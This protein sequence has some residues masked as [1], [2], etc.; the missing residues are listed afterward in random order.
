MTLLSLY[1]FFF[2]DTATT[3][4]YTLSLHDAL[5]ILEAFASCGADLLLAGHLHVGHAGHTAERYQIGNH[6][7]LFV[8]AG[9]AT[10]TRVRGDESNSFNGIRLKRPHIQVE[11]RVWQTGARSFKAGPAET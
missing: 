10:S 1:I 8:Q 11:R 9:T 7:A 3:E 4:I 6:S 2:N 5:P